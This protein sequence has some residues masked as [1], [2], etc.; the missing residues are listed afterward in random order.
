MFPE[1]TESSRSSARLFAAGWFALFG[2][3]YIGYR[4]CPARPSRLAVM[5]V[6][7]FPILFSLALYWASPFSTIPNQYSS[8]PLYR[9]VVWHDTTLPYGPFWAVPAAITSKLAGND[10]LANLFGFKLMVTLHFWAGMALLYHTLQLLHPEHTLRGLFLYAWNPLMQFEVAGNGHLEAMLIF[11]MLVA[12]YFLVRRQYL[13]MLLGLAGACL[14]KFTLAIVVPLF[15]IGMWQAYAQK[16]LMYRMKQIV[17]GMGAMGVTVLLLYL[18]FGGI[19]SSIPGMKYL[20]DLFLASIPTMLLY[21]FRDDRGVEVQTAQD[22]VHYIFLTIIS[23]I[24]LWQCLRLWRLH[25]PTHRQIVYRVLQGSFEISFAYLLLAS[26]WF[27]PWYVLWLLAF[28]PFLHFFGYAERATFFCL[29]VLSHYFTFAYFGFW[30]NLDPRAANT[31]SVWYIYPLPFL[32]TVL[33][34]LYRL[35]IP[36]MPQA[37]RESEHRS[38]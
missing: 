9:Y 25:I 18:P 29:T 17:L 5:I 7:L 28:A 11:W 27:E 31:L 38:G 32:F 37:I 35:R 1:I 26:F 24:I 23:S 14:V 16:P 20:K 36:Y 33:L 19:Q 12:I 2:L 10:L 30:Y 6:S 21:V 13:L 8:D 4:L 34:R 3:Y 22:I 15:L